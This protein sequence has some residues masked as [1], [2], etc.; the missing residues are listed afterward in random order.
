[1]NTPIGRIFLAVLLAV[2]VLFIALVSIRSDNSLIPL[3]VRN[4]SPAGAMALY[5]WLE[6]SGYQVRQITAEPYV[7]NNIDVLFILEPTESYSPSDV[8][9]IREWVQAGG[10]LVLAADG[11]MAAEL[12]NALGIQ[13]DFVGREI[14]T[15]TPLVPTLLNPPF[16]QLEVRTNHVFKFADRPDAVLHFAA[17]SGGVVMSLAEEKGQVW[18]MSATYPLTNQGLHAEESVAFAQNLVAGVP[19][20]AVIGFDERHHGY[21]GAA[22][23]LLRWL[24]T[25]APGLGVTLLFVLTFIYLALRGRRFG[26]AV[27]VQ[28]DR[29][30]RE[31]VEYIY[32]MAGLLRRSDSRAMLTQH[33]RQ[34]FRRQLSERFGIDSRLDDDAVF[35]SIAARLPQADLDGLARLLRPPSKTMN[36]TQLHQYVETLDRWLK[37]NS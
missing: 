14:E 16:D 19:H 17:E 20:G 21:V 8:V 12:I 2:I 13:S 25:T 6:R 29:L 23:T 3:S 33:Y 4:D 1:M 36:E 22:S 31:P 9:V 18:L 37:E 35:K 27:P 28:E 24:L 11:Q 30:R 7:L 32:A 15:L 10:R 26:K 5:Q 34:R